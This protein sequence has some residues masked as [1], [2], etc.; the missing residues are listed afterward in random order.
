MY[1][2]YGSTVTDANRGIGLRIAECWLDH[3]ASIIYSIDVDDT[4]GAFDSLPRRFP[5]QFF[6]LK[7][8]VT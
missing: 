4:G 5:N 7:A 3:G 8:D 2:N 6:A 1:V